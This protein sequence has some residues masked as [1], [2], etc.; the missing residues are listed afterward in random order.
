MN[1]K[2]TIQKM[3]QLID[4]TKDKGKRAFFYKILFALKKHKQLY[5]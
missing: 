1:T 3:Q 4:E 2:K 5:I